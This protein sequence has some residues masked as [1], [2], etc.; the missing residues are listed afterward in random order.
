M[1]FTNSAVELLPIRAEEPR[2]ER[3]E[4]REGVGLADDY[5]AF[6]V[7]DVYG[8]STKDASMIFIKLI[9]I[10][11]KVELLLSFYNEGSQHSDNFIMQSEDFLDVI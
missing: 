11:G 1:S 2:V 9:A 10:F 5:K 3:R 6:S 7:N 8:I 4:P